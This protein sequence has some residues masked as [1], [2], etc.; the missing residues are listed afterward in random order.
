[1]RL[2][3]GKEKLIFCRHCNI[4]S[5]HERIQGKIEEYFVLNPKILKNNEQ[6][7]V[8]I[9]NVCNRMFVTPSCMSHMPDTLTS[10]S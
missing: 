8:L 10:R 1:M 5:N 3:E 7:L 2:L 9:L 4:W 6:S